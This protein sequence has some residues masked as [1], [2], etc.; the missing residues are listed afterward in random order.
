MWTALSPAMPLENLAITIDRLTIERQSVD[1][2]FEA[3]VQ[4]YKNRIHSYICRLTN[5][6]PD[7]EDI[8]QEV[9]VRAY[10]GMRAF[11]RDAALDTWLYRIATNLVIDRYR[12]E[13]RAPQWVAVSGDADDP[14]LDL[15]STSRHGDPEATVALSELQ[16][17][18]QRAIQSLPPKLRA[19]VVLY[20]MEGLAYEQVAETLGCPVGTVK[21]RLFNAR[22]LLRKKLARYVT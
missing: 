17:H 11:R 15:P 12:K 22:T 16:R 3:L 8:T 4:D 1:R 19:V 20:D 9:F 2:Q 6:S 18:V 13:K 21:S 14:A 7:A 5:D 10:Q